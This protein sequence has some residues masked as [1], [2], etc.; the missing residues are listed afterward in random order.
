MPDNWSTAVVWCLILAIAIEGI[1]CLLRF[2]LQLEATRDTCFLSA[3]TFGLRIHHCYLGLA[4]GIAG[5]FLAREDALNWWL[6]VGAA[7]V[8]SD[9]AHHFVVLWLVTGQPEFDLF[10]P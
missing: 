10:Y 2:S 1:T 7:F 5:V 8:L 4:V 6:I 9:L 3:L